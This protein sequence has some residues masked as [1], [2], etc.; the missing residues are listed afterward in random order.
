MVTHDP[1]AA[2]YGDRLVTIRDGLLHAEPAD[3]Q[4]AKWSVI[5]G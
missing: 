1:G 4:K 3:R 5:G 2:A